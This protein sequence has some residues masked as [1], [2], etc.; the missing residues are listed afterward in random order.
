MNLLWAF[1][2]GPEIDQETGKQL[3]VDI[4]NYDEVRVFPL[5]PVNRRLILL[6][7]GLGIC[8]APFMCTITP[9]SAHH[10]EVIEHEFA[11]AE[12]DFAPYEHGLDEEDRAFVEAQRR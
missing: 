7:Q 3:P 8:P 1:D 10:A 12:G 11:A 9:R 5:I 4:F 6:M 2:F